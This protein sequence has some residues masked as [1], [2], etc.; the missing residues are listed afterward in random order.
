MHL[1][2]IGMFVGYILNPV[3]NRLLQKLKD[4]IKR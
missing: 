2:L 3:I 1:I 4:S